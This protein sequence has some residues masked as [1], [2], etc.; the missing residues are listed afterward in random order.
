MT[1]FPRCWPANE[2]LQDRGLAGA[3]ASHHG[4]LRQ[5][6][7][8]M[9]AQLGEGVLH[10]VDDGDERL[11]A[12]IARHVGGGPAGRGL[13]DWLL[14]SRDGWGEEEEDGAA[15]KHQQVPGLCAAAAT[16]LWLVNQ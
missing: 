14:A 9:D 8:H 11:H 12:L 10:P 2:V 1:T 5:V 4:N 15:S 7:G 16:P 6:D 3:L 13:A